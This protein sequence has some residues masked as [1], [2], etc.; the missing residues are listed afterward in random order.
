MS[1]GEFVGTLLDRCVDWLGRNAL[2][3]VFVMIALGGAAV[4]EW[5]RP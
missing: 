3:I 4:F 2:R 1:E 5:V